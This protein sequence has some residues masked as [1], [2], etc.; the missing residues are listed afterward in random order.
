MRRSGSAE[1]AQYACPL[2]A[3]DDALAG[4]DVLAQRIV[5]RALRTVSGGA[6]TPRSLRG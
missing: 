3:S 5:A 6:A 2:A 1:L 4:A